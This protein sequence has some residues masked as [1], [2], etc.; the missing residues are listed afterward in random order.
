M[1]KAYSGELFERHSF[2][3]LEKDCLPEKC[4]EGKTGRAVFEEWISRSFPFV[5]KR[6]C[7]SDDGKSIHCGIPLPPSRGKLRLGYIVRRESVEAVF[8]PPSLKE[9]LSAA[10]EN[11]RD[12]L[13]RLN[14]TAEK[15]GFSP[16]VFGSLAWQSVTGENYLSEN[17]DTDLI[18]KIESPGHFEMMGKVF[19]EEMAAS[20][21]KYDVEI[22]MPDGNSFSWNEY[23]KGAEKILIKGNK[24][25]WLSSR[26]TLLNEMACLQSICGER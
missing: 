2:I 4:V 8:N 13:E 18:F 5:V 19:E 23:R 22:K 12:E 6:P 9:C 7:V 14:M 25:V 26:A 1:G 17:S 10:P 3:R 21:L 16:L 15:Y 20:A 24:G 11:I